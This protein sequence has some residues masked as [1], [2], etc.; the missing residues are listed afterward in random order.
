MGMDDTIPM[1]PQFSR[2]HFDRITVFVL[3]DPPADVVP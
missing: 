1:G 3:G 2:E